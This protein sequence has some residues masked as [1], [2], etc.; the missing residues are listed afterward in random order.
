[1]SDKKKIKI[2]LDNDTDAVGEVVVVLAVT[3]FAL[4]IASQLLSLI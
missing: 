1:M 3:M 4:W 2:Q